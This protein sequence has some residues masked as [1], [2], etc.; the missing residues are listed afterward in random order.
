[1]LWILVNEVGNKWGDISRYIDGRRPGTLKNKWA[2]FK[3]ELKDE[4]KRLYDCMDS[5]GHT[6]EARATSQQGWI[7]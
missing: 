5:D 6:V 7:S 1:M 4:C 2:Y 3:E